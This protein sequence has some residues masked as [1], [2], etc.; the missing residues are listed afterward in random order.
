MK[1]NVKVFMLTMH[2]IIE[3]FFNVNGKKEKDIEEERSK[4]V[5]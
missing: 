1:D 3:L 5:K 4:K 2:I